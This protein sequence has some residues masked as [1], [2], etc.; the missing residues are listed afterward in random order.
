MR[1]NKHRPPAAFT[2]IEICISLALCILVVGLSLPRFTFF[3][4]FFLRQDIDKLWHVV[5]YLQQ[6]AIASG[7]EQSLL[8]NPTTYTYTFKSTANSLITISLSSQIIFGALPTTWG[9]P[10]RTDALITDPISFPHQETPPHFHCLKIFS[11]GKI[12]PGTIYLCDRNK[13]IMAA[14]TCSISQVSYIRRYLYEKGQW[15]AL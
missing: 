1:E 2:L 3:K 5:T 13:Q 10:G 9:P 8:F 11:N 4:Q 15:T 14:L 7:S 6:R 12:Y